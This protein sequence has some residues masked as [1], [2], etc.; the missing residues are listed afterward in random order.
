MKPIIRP[1][2]I[3]FRVDV[4][5]SVDELNVAPYKFA[6]VILQFINT[7]EDKFISL[8]S[9]DG[10]EREYVLFC[11]T[12]TIVIIFEPENAVKFVVSL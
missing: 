2:R 12:T 7:V 5:K 3:E 4:L 11:P 1:E 9:R 8:K 6:P 10:I